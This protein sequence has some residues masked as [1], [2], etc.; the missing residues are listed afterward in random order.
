MLCSWS[1]RAKAA[2]KEKL[3]QSQ[4]H[5]G[6]RPGTFQRSLEKL[7]L[8]VCAQEPSQEA[9][10][11]AYLRLADSKLS[12][13]M[14]DDSYGESDLPKGAARALRVCRQLRGFKQPRSRASNAVFHQGSFLLVLIINV[15]D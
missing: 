6:R 10:Q 15:Q 12:V 2:G 8:K 7:K 9:R 5:G 4:E 14:S 11:E 3:S 1:P 13:K